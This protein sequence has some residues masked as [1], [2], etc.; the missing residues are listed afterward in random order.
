MNPGF[1]LA[2]LDDFVYE[3]N[4]ILFNEGDRIILYTDGVTE[5]RDDKKS[6][7]EKKD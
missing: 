3:E 5:A 2:G 4:A 1:V 6:F 7:L